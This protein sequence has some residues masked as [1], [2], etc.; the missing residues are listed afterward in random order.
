V[1]DFVVRRAELLV[2]LAVVPVILLLPGGVPGGVLGLGLVSAASL[3]M[4]AAG[5]VLVFR[6]NRFI[7]F[8]QVQ[9]G[10][11]AGTLFALLVNAQPLLRGVR[12]ACPPCLE[13][14]TPL[15][16]D[17]SYWVSLALS[18]AFGIGLSWLVY[19]LV[20]RKLER[21]PRL[22]LTVASIFLITLLAGVQRLLITV[23]TTEDQRTFGGILKPVPPPLDLEWQTR[24]AR[25]VTADFLTVGVA[26]AALVGIA[27]YLSRSRTGNAIRATAENP[28]RAQTLGVDV[29]S[30]TSRVWLL[31]GAL[32]TA[33]ALLATMASPGGDGTTASG[34]GS[35]VRVLVVVV[36][37]RFVS[38]PM[39]GL[40]ALAF[41]LL[42]Q[43]VQYSAGSTTVLDGSLVVVISGL[44]LLQRRETGRADRDTSSAYLAGRQ[45]RPVPPELQGVPAVVTMRRTF[46]GVVAVL[47]LASPFVLSPS[48]TSTLATTVVFAIVGMSLLVLTGWAGQVSLGQ[49]G[50]AAIGAY[51]AAVSGLPFLPA[52]L[53][54]A[55]AGAL[56]AVLVGL[57]A[58]RLQGLTLAVSTLAFA[59]AVVVVLLN[60]DQLGRHLPDSLAAP[61]L[62]GMSLAD[63]RTFY[64]VALL[65]LVLTVVA[66]MGL[67]RSRTARVL[68]AAR[69]NEAAAQSFG[70]S[71]LRA[72]L[73]AFAVAGFLAATAGVLFA[74]QQGFVAASAFSVQQSLVLFTFTVIGGLGSIAGPLV[75]FAALAIL[76]LSTQS[77]GWL[78]TIN[79]LGGIA[80]L[81]LA[82]G[83]LAQVGLDLRDGMLRRIARRSGITV[84]SL[85]QETAA[86]V[87]PI[88]PGTSFVP[89]RYA[90]DGQWATTAGARAAVEAGR[91]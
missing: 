48:Q 41:G 86:G 31:V 87:A 52:L 65:F 64:Y 14:V 57:P 60:P 62:L 30:V 77:P 33:A 78:A 36:V 67:R 59:S 11:V 40:A 84:P 46:A 51:V 42:S 37:A 39:A 35:L 5:V 82:P 34:V 85:A 18:L 44:L 4:Q 53:L 17:I 16:L 63:A 32:S 6:S 38:L 74:Y 55:V 22:V 43:A 13:R 73:S 28:A 91:D 58:L 45:A 76:S 2:L 47:L 9:I 23:L 20:V 27:L 83:G 70:I 25:F 88:A 75:G 10:A 54:G 8:A 90:L 15:Q 71:L 12:A 89:R 49:F 79:G 56:V 69:D 81:L 24:S 21:A 68:V 50:F 29:V 3:A 19:L 66:V 26:V 1:R 80:L 72:R 61:Q 7:N